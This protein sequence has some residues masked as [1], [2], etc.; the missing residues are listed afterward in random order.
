[1]RWHKH[2][3]S[4]PSSCQQYRYIVARRCQWHQRLPG[5]FNWSV[6]QFILMC[7][8]SFST[9]LVPTLIKF[10]RRKFNYRIDE[11]YLRL[12]I[13]S[14]K[15]ETQNCHFDTIYNCIVIINNWIERVFVYVRACDVITDQSLQYLHLYPTSP[16]YIIL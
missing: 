11:I 14:I 3:I 9:W 7:L 15:R 10:Q 12:S 8:L 1:M 13:T 4:Y 6:D 16:F 2:E 5:R